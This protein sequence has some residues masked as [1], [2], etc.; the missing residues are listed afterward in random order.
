MAEF[1]EAC[2]LEIGN[3]HGDFRGLTKQEDWDNGKAERVICEGCG[4]I[5]VDPS[6]NCR[7]N[8]C[9]KAGSHGHGR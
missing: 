9:L 5:Q 6:G 1:C 7:S 8:N 2:A 4:L 3:P